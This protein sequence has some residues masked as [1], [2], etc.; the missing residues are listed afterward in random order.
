MGSV[1][2]DLTHT[3]LPGTECACVLIFPVERACHVQVQA[4]R[5]RNN[6]MGKL[7][8]TTRGHSR[9]VAMLSVARFRE[10]V[11][12]GTQC[13]RQLVPTIELAR[14]LERDELATLKV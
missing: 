9:A 11:A 3:L 8:D 2:I 1:F 12:A 6:L 4:F 10:M 14:L 5:G 13:E 7:N